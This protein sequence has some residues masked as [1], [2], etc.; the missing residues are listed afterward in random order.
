MFNLRIKTAS[1]VTSKNT[2]VVLGYFWTLDYTSLKI[3][4]SLLKII[5]STPWLKN[6]RTI[7]VVLLEM[8]L[9]Y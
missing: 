7:K 5:H 3:T 1:F 9:V 6:L 8:V 4:L 2:Y